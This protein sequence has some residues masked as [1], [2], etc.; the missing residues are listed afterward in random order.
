M[1]GKVATI[2]KGVLGQKLRKYNITVPQFA[3]MA[4]VRETKGASPTDLAQVVDGDMPTTVRIIS[5][6][7]KKGLVYRQDS[8]L[9]KR[10]YL[11]YLTP[12]GSELMEKSIPLAF[13]VTNTTLTGFEANEIQY[14]YSVVMRMLRNFS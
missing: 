11:V 4:A 3:L 2:M 13:E 12:E 1:F 6:L 7:E 8:E 5:K 10:S 9:D 14:L